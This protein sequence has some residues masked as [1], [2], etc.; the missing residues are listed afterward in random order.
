MS[1]W[2]GKLKKGWFGQGDVTFPPLPQLPDLPDVPAFPAGTTVTTTGTTTF[3]GFSSFRY[4]TSV[5][6]DDLKRFNAQA[7]F[8]N[9]MT[10]VDDF[11]DEERVELFNKLVTRMGAP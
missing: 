7:A 1:G 6:M 4:N 5:T 11:T 3:T 8:A 2:W 9:A 10:H